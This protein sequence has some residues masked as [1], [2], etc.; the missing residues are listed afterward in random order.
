MSGLCDGRNRVLTGYLS[1]SLAVIER[2]LPC[3]I[4]M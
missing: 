3:R 4:G 2:R 1:L